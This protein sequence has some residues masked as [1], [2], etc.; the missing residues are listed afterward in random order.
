MDQQDSLQ[1]VL[2]AADKRRAERREFFRYASGFGIAAAGAAVLSACGS[3]DDDDDSGTVTVTATAT[4][5]P[6][7]TPTPSATITVT[8]ADILNFALNLEYLEAQFYSFAANGTGLAAGLL[9]GTGTAGAATGGRQVTFTDPLV[10]RY[11]REI[12]A[13]EQGHVAFLRRTLGTAAIAQPAIDLSPAA[14]GAFAAAAVAAGLI[15]TGQPFDPYA[16]DENFLLAAFLFEDVGVSAY[17]GAIGYLATTSY[18]DATAGIQAAEAYHAGLIRTVLYRK[19]VDTPSLV[20]ASEKISTARDT[21]DGSGDI[22]QGV[23]MV[24][25]ASNIVPSDG[26]GIA[27]ARSPYQVLNIAYLTNA[28]ATKGGFFPNGV[29]GVVNSSVAT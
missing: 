28:A 5:T 4:P 9:S 16:S 1:Q 27:F 26:T 7:P 29:N 14:T 22:D 25:G 21:L 20:E 6:T 23:K 12:A 10:A 2:E 17:K 13:D 24:N 15:E 18:I 3:D 19:G 8:E 11:A